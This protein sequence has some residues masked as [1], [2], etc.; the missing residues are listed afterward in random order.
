MPQGAGEEGQ[1]GP[2]GASPE[3][4][5][6][7]AGQRN[8]IEEADAKA[9]VLGTAAGAGTKPPNSAPD[10]AAANGAVE[11]GDSEKPPEHEHAVL[12]EEGD[13]VTNPKPVSYFSLYRWAS[14]ESQPAVLHV[15]RTVAWPGSAA[16]GSSRHG[17]RSTFHA[18]SRPLACNAC[19]LP[20]CVLRTWRCMH[21]GAVEVGAMYLCG[22]Y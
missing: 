6:G 11:N 14:L 22:W 12:P 9:V 21:T 2:A 15:P 4:A 19:C 10:A 17:G 18:L 3:A 5:D 13:K 8:G 1:Q 20:S 7:P 16:A